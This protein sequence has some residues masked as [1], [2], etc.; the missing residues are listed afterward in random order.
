M[1][2]V[3]LAQILVSLYNV[4][5]KPCQLDKSFIHNNKYALT[6][7]HSMEEIV[8]SVKLYNYFILNDPYK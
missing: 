8:V 4:N 1:P 6:V 7:I 5:F 3:P 2:F